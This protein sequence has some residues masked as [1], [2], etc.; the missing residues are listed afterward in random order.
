MDDEYREGVANDVLHCIA[1]LHG[2]VPLSSEV[3]EVA[4]VLLETVDLNGYG[5]E[6]W[7]RLTVQDV[8]GQ[9]S[10][11]HA[12]GRLDDLI[13]RLVKENAD[14]KFLSGIEPA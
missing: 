11:V 2:G 4:E 1:G 5:V 10:V 6:V 12:P 14:A 3:T 13:V 8:E 9:L 7:T